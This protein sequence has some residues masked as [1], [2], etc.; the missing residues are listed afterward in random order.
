[1]REATNVRREGGY[2]V[3][4]FTLTGD[5]DERTYIRRTCFLSEAEHLG[6]GAYRFTLAT[7]YEDPA[8]VKGVL[9]AVV[10][11]YRIENAT[12]P[13]ELGCYVRDIRYGPNIVE[14]DIHIPTENVTVR[15]LEIWGRIVGVEEGPL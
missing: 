6:E 7:V 12:Q 11:H 9:H 13:V 1:M 15:A 8:P 10:S 3:E 5:N 2:I 14:L 4:Q